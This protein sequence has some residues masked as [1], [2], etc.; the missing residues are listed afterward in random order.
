MLVFLKC[1]SLFVAVCTNELVINSKQVNY[2]EMFMLSL[3]LELYNNSLGSGIKLLKDY[4][5]FRK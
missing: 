3:A 2:F 5:L 1:H 4:A